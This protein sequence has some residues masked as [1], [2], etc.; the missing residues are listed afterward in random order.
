[1]R[2]N[3]AR[4]IAIFVG[5]LILVSSLGLGIVTFITS[6]NVVRSQAKQALDELAKEGVNHI[7]SA[8]QSNINIVIELANRDDIKSMDFEMQKEALKDDIE[9]LGYLDIGIAYPYGKAKYILSGETIDIA[10]REYFQNIRSGQANV[11][12]I[13]TS[14]VNSEKIVIYVSPIEDDGRIVGALIAKMDARNLNE[15]TKDMGFGESGYA[16]ILSEDG[17]FYSHPNEELV[18][19][20]KNILE[21]IEAGGEFKD[22]ALAFEE[23]GLGN[24]GNIDYVYKASKRYMG[25]DVIPSTGWILAVGAY[26]KEIFAGLVSMQKRSIFIV[27]I[28]TVIGIGLAVLLGRNISRPIVVLSGIMDRFSRYDI[29][30]EE[31][32]KV[33]KYIKRKDEVGDIS[34]S[35]RTMQGNFIDLISNVA[36]QSKGV[37][38]SSEQLTATSQ[39]S[40]LASEEVARAIEDIASG[41]SDQARDTETGASGIQELGRQVEIVQGV[42]ENLYKSSEEIEGLKDEGIEIMR[43]L[44]EKT[45][46]NRI[47]AK[48]IYGVIIATNDSA[49]NINNVSQMIK[50]I[51]EQTN[52]L[53]LNAAIEAARAGE[54]GRGFAV[55]AEEI[56]KLAEDSSNFTKDIENI[57]KELTNK[58]GDSVSKIKEVGEITESQTNSVNLTN[59]KF[60]DIAVKIDEINNLV[61]NSDSSI[62][63][64]ASKKDEIIM[65]IEQLSAI[66]EENAAATE[67][68]SASVEEQAASIEEISNFSGTLAALAHEMEENINKFKY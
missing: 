54:A 38:S 51:A 43:N 34:K 44:V 6:S 13:I 18:L 11:S 50:S 35:L 55:V 32:S 10:D 61:S 17:T 9:R 41:A 42:I 49:K 21:D 57:I 27:F 59:K 22:G 20:Q 36:Q 16:F 12:D 52:L 40:E 48:D 14:K 15:I 8:I 53:A 33:D 4:R 5:V 45:E 2:I 19:N 63:V 23:L 37:A 60:E 28:F 56:R 64:M 46:L 67:E 26:E 3:L 1:M 68:A 7:E 39:Q 62:N 31:D 29:S 65:I 25:V 24:K 58:T 47:A 66:A 30:I